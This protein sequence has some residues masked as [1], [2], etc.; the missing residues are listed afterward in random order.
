[1]PNKKREK[2]FDLSKLKS[3]P[4]NPRYITR[5]QLEKLKKSIKQFEKMMSL[6]PIIY[7]EE[8]VILGGNMRFEALNSLGYMKVPQS[9]VKLAEGL[10][11][12]E[13][14]E[15]IIKDNVG[16]GSWDWELLAN[17]WELD[18]LEDWGL[19]VMQGPEED[20]EEG[21]ESSG[22]SEEYSQKIVAPT[23]EPKEEEPPKIEELFDRSKTTQLEEQIK[24]EGLPPE[25]ESFLIAAAQRHTIINFEKVA[26][27]YAHASPGVQ[28]LFEASALVIID[29]DKAIESGYVRLSEEIKEQYLK[30]NDV[31]F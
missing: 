30:D 27:Y 23:Y 20:E 18:E 26:E 6:R 17:G 14:K 7:D 5:D 22:A 25:I 11:E 21:G 15:F 29:F 12:A 16:F 28:E 24:R 2:E 1:M 4:G 3:N 13:K 9:W 31:A 19:S 8:G 10:T